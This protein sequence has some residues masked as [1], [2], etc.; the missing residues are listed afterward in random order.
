MAPPGWTRPEQR[1]W[2]GERNPACAEARRRSAFGTWVESVHQEWFLKWPERRELYGNWEGPLTYEQWLELGKAIELRRMKIINW[3]NN[4]KNRNRDAQSLPASITAAILKGT[5]SCKCLPQA[6]EVYCRHFYSDEQRAIAKEELATER[7]RLGRKLTRK[8]RMTLSRRR[9]DAFYDAE[10][11]D[12]KARVLAKLEEEKQALRSE[13][14]L[15]TDPGKK[16]RTPQE[17]QTA[18]DRA[19]EIVEKLLQPVHEDSGWVIHVTGAGP[20]PEHGGDI[21]TF[22]VHFG[23]NKFSQSLGEA[24]EDYRDKFIRPL[25]SFAK[26][27]YP[28]EVRRSRA[29]LTGEPEDEDD[30]DLLGEDDKDDDEDAVQASPS[31]SGSSSARVPKSRPSAPSSLPSAPPRLAAGMQYASPAVQPMAGAIVPSALDVLSAA[32]VAMADSERPMAHSSD[33]AHEVPIDEFNFPIATPFT[34]DSAHST[35]SY[36][37]PWQSG[38]PSDDV[39]DPV[40]FTQTGLTSAHWACYQEEGESGCGA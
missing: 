3:F 5:G 13:P 29:L 25:R 6:R 14:P 8:E 38:E 32:A 36:M 40:S 31:G 22:S 35:T 24:V 10:S 33:T 18:I 20:S 16:Q 21:R 11:D 34:F 7:A 12:L 23:L 1:D 15:P 28:P 30:D 39:F 9:V 19:P 17:Y 2:L 26:S 4:H 37:T 27:V